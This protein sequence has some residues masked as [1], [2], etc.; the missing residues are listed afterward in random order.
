MR[1]HL[2]R[3]LAMCCGG[4]ME[5]YIEPLAQSR[6]ALETALAMWGK[7]RPAELV[8]P[9]DGGAKRVI[10]RAV[11][12]SREG[13]IAAVPNQAGECFVEA[14]WPTDRVLL[15]GCGHVGRE[16][17]ALAARCGFEVVICDDGETGAVAEPPAWATRIVESFEVR[18]V[19]RELGPIGAGDHAL[20]VT[21][22]HAVDQR[23]LEALL[24]R[25]ELTYLGMIGSLGKVGRFRKRLEAKGL[26]TEERWGRLHAPVGL[27]IGAETPE[28]IAV[29]IVGELI[30]VRRR[31]SR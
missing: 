17:G 11:H 8:T 19:E 9:L 31:G 18:D 23:I 7:R 16:V 30:A 12:G 20:I 6:A 15:F 13:R 2:V 29:A 22:D 28:E 14:V 26:L 27:D 24:P 21:R 25:L 3:D 1:H 10:E 5:I 4:S